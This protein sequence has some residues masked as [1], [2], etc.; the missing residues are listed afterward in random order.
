MK[1]NLIYKFL[2]IEIVISL[3]AAYIIYDAPF[4]TKESNDR[5]KQFE[6]LLTDERELTLDEEQEKEITKYMDEHPGNVILFYPD[7][8]YETWFLNYSKKFIVVFSILFIASCIIM[9]LNKL[10]GKYA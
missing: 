8:T 10:R 5:I 9:F 4:P 7:I 6:S 1:R 2:I 3:I